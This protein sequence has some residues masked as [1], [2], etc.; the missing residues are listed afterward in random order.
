MSVKSALNKLHTIEADMIAGAR[1]LN[2]QEARYLVDTFYQM[3]EFRKATANQARAMSASGEPHAII[4]S[5]L[6]H[7]GA[8]E[9][10]VAGAL[11][12]YVR[13]T[14]PGRWMLAQ[15][16]VGPILAANMLAHL[17]VTKTATA[18]GF[19]RFAGLDPSL[20]WGK[21]QK[22]P[23]NARLKTACWKL[24]DSFV[25]LGSKDAYY[26][27]VY[28][29]RKAFEVSRNDAGEFAEQA[30]TALVE[31]NY[32]KETEA[33]KAYEQGKLPPGRLD[34]RARRYAVKLFLAHLHHVMYED[35]YG[36]PPPKPYAI[37]HLG[38]AHY[39]APPGEVA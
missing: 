25:K 30:K 6:V 23:Y 9:E 16:G 32:G 1:E 34:L 24:S 26:A 11:T 12:P 38:H 37:E 29:E 14:R 19:W 5:V 36:E 15:S 8:L 17:D 7:T 27:K 10:F 2:G 18:G 28:R 20:K 31:K 39:L 35:H 3:Q 13:S 33:R 4:D 21:G 22:R